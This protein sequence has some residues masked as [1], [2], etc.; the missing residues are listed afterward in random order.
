MTLG[1]GKQKCCFALP[2]NLIL[3]ISS[4]GSSKKVAIRRYWGFPPNSRRKLMMTIRL[5]DYLG[6]VEARKAALG[7]ADT[8]ADADALRNK[9]ARRT[10]EKRELLRR[11]R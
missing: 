1:C 11:A 3:T 10:P 2:R 9:G 5:R 7:M 4:A 6:Q 8:A